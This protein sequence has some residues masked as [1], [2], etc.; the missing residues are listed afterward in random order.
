MA[1]ST[2][3]REEYRRFEAV[4]PEYSL[5]AST[6]RTLHQPGGDGKPFCKHTAEEWRAVDSVEALRYGA[7][8][9]RHCY[10]PVCDYFAD[11][12]DSP[13]ERREA[14]EER[15]HTADA[16]P[17]GDVLA[18]GGL[19]PPTGGV[20]SAKTEEVLTASGSK[21]YHAPSGDEPLC[22]SNGDFRRA[23]LDVLDGHH[24]PCSECFDLDDG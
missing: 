4:L 8:P 24:R 6:S 17:A 1:G 15:D 16:K 5:M 11:V 7:V 3:L 10:A 12:D 21:I 18:D 22:N 9:C 20:L 2:D 23:D 19:K 14:D 13:V